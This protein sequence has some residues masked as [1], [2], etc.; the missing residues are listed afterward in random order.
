MLVCTLAVR[1]TGYTQLHTSTKNN[2]L[3]HTSRILQQLPLL[4]VLAD[5]VRKVHIFLSVLRYQH[6]LHHA[7][8][9]L[10][11]NIHILLA[12]AHTH[13]HSRTLS[14]M[15]RHTQTHARTYTR[16]HMH[17]NAS[18]VTGI[19]SLLPLLSSSVY[20]SLSYSVDRILV[21]HPPKKTKTV[22]FV[23]NSFSYVCS[24]R[25]NTYTTSE[26]LDKSGI[27]FSIVFLAFAYSV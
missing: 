6:R 26:Y 24:C 23:R 20:L 9:H 2:T 7:C 3:P 16:T 11:F 27:T 10:V 14:H 5:K 13:T 18:V 19:L 1:V 4:H 8:A 12:Y 25:V 17:S 22:V 21:S 15:V